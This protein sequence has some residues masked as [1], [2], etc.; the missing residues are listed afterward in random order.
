M[1]NHEFC[2]DY[3]CSYIIIHWTL[4]FLQKTLKTRGEWTE[5]VAYF[6]PWVITVQITNIKD[7]NKHQQVLKI[8]LLHRKSWF[9]MCSTAPDSIITSPSMEEWTQKGVV[10]SHSKVCLIAKFSIC[11]ILKSA[12]SAATKTKLNENVSP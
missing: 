9:F 12:T 8:V 10:H 2:V 5:L 6:L 7:N 4:R 11:D 3:D 1:I